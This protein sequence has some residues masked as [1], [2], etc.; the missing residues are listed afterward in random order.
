MWYFNVSDPP[1][2]QFV[3][4]GFLAEQMSKVW[5]RSLKMMHQVEF[6]ITLEKIISKNRN[7]LQQK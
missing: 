5:D 3:V 2:M 1:Y 4:W 7:L 6:G